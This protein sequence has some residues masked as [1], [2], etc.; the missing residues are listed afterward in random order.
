MGIDHIQVNFLA[1]RKNLKAAA[2]RSGRNESDIRLVT[3]GKTRSIDE[4]SA[5]IASGATDIG[6]NRVQE[7]VAK[8]S[9]FD[10]DVNWHF[11]GALA[12]QVQQQ[13]SQDFLGQHPVW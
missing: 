1:V 3:V 5:A 8:E 6:E 13:V 10:A 4:I 9:Q 2:D 12:C 11:I 7:L